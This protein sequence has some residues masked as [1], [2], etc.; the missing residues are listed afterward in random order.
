MPKFSRRRFAGLLIAPLFRL[1]R[2]SAQ[3]V[4]ATTES[5]SRTTSRNY[6]ADAVILLLGITIFR[7]PGVGGGKASLEETGEGAALRRTPAPCGAIMQCSLAR[8][9]VSR[10]RLC[11]TD[12][13]FLSS[14][15]M[16]VPPAKVHEKPSDTLWGG[17]PGPRP[18]PSSASAGLAGSGSRGTRA[19]QGVRPT[20]WFFD[21]QHPKTARVDRR[22]KPIVCPTV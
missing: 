11:R 8:S 5:P 18:T 7:R 15:G 3:S 9:C 4:P 12:D 20:K 13:R 22:H 6:R 16:G 21:Q 14:V 2:L 10:L 17:P 1:P 19:D